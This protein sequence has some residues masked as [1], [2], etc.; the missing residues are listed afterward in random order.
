MKLIR[1][2]VSIPESLSKK[3]DEH[4][5]K[6][7]YS[8]RSEALRDLIRKELIQEEIEQDMEVV[9]V[10]NL[11]YDHHKRE[12]TDKLT[13]LQHNHHHI[14]LSTM[15]IHLDHRNC[16]EVILL[17]GR[18]QEVK[19]LADALIATKGVKHGNLNLTSTGKHLV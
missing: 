19:D 6:K 9:G 18:S 3:F 11:L 4:I 13:E 17:R 5:R 12:L 14:V 15:H 10:V 7:H 2:G 16:L 8:N 1:F